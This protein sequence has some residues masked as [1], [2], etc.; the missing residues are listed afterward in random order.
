[1]ALPR[2]SSRVI[3]ALTAATGLTL[4]TLPVGA[5][6]TPSVG[7]AVSRLTVLRVTLNGD[8]V[9][10]GD[11]RAVADNAA[12]HVAK[13]VITPLDSSL[14]G[15]VGQQTI[16]PSDGDSTVPGTPKSV[17]LPDSGTALLNITGPTFGAEAVDNATQV[18]ATAV[19]DAL[20]QI[21]LLTV[22]LDL[23]AAELSDVAKVT[24]STA[25]ATKTLSVGGLALPS[26]QDLLASLGIDLD[27]LLEQITQGRLNDLV[28]LIGGNVDALNTAVDDAQAGLSA[29]TGTQAPRTFAGA[30]A[31]LSSAQD[32]RDAADADLSDANAAFDAALDTIWAAQTGIVQTALSAA[33]LDNTTTADEFLALDNTALTTIAGLLSG[34]DFSNLTDL[35]DAVAVAETALAAAQAVVDAANALVDALQDLVNGVL[36]I[37]QG[38]DDPLAALSDIEV[39]TSAVA[40]KTPTA[41]ADV[42]VGDVHVLGALTPLNSLTSVLGGVTDTLSGVLES[43]AGVSFTAPKIAVGT[44]ATSTDQQGQTRFAAASITGVTLTLP[45]LSISGAAPAGL[46]LAGIPDGVSGSV[47]IGQLAETASW[48]PAGATVTDNPNNPNSPTPNTPNG[49]SPLPDT[50]GRVL[51]P[52][53]GLLTLGAGLA[54]RRRLAS[55]QGL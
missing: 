43:V 12:P 23:S 10:A 34:T 27:T 24:S 4:L 5:A 55:G 31:Q 17:S 16:T 29:L 18:S 39:T 53:I 40:A 35:A 50:G 20:G 45:E 52:F 19:L 13:L 32:D 6:T 25:S 44:P 41:D 15:P 14:T 1:V 54:L 11:L 30:T 38:S 37:V 8:F 42:S 26:I 46:E 28:D 3:V 22:P 2:P 9:D 36:D 33:G 51:L 48:T 47:V 21:D 7:S 49:G